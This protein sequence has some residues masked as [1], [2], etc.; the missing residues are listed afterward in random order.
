MQDKST[1]PGRNRQIGVFVLILG[2][3]ALFCCGAGTMGALWAYT[4]AVS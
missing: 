4:S 1:Q 3:V 2:A